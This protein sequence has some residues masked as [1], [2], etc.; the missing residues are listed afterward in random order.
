VLFRSSTANVF[1]IGSIPGRFPASKKLFG[2]LR[3]RKIL[4]D[5]IKLDEKEKSDANKIICQFSSIG[6]LGPN[7]N[8][9]LCKEFITS[10]SSS[11][12]SNLKPASLEPIC[13]YPSVENVRTSFEGYSAGNSLPYMS[14][15]AQKQ[16]YL[17][18]FLHKWKADQVG[19]TK[20]SPHIKSFARFSDD[21]KKMYWFLLTSSNL[22]KAAWGAFEKN[23]S[24]LFI[25]SYEIGVLFVPQYLLKDNEENYFDLESKNCLTVP[26]DLPPAKYD[27]DDEPWCVD[28]PHKKP[29]T[30]GHTYPMLF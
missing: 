8:S 15:T 20:A 25:R 3:L 5:N 10:L 29:D 4:S 6:S 26:Y 30:H 11:V 28:I 2:H 18:K 27:A 22:S 17:N 16:V 9:W 7:E 1:L 19:R 14:R 13:I 21:Y 23:E 24:Q 12:N